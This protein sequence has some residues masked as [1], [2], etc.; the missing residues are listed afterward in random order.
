MNDDEVGTACV[1]DEKVGFQPYN[2]E[3]SLDRQGDFGAFLRCF[4]QNARLRRSGD[5]HQLCFDAGK[6]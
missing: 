6:R 2:A 1:L 4:D 3:R 5:I